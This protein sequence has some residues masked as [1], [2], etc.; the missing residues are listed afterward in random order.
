MRRW[1]MPLFRQM[2]EWSVLNAGVVLRER[3]GG[4]L[5][6]TGLELKLSLAKD[7]AN[8]GRRVDRPLPLQP[9][10]GASSSS[11]E[12]DEPL[13]TNKLR[14]RR[15]LCHTPIERM[16]RMECRV[17]LQRKMTRYFCQTCDKAVCLGTCWTRYHTKLHYLFDDPNCKGKKIF[18]KTID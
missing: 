18:K 4:K 2:I 15:D 8:L 6:W 16:P 12:L 5:L 7:L 13:L 14:L 11:D 10:A 1:Y 17:H 9:A 3:P